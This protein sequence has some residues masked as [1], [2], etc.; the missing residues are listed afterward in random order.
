MYLKRLES[1]LV[2]ITILGTGRGQT[3]RQ[4]PKPAAT[5]E[6]KTLEITKGTVASSIPLID[7]MIAPVHCSSDGTLYF[8]GLHNPATEPISQLYS[9]SSQGEG[10]HIARILPTDY[11]RTLV[12]DLFAG[13]HSLATLIEASQPLSNV[14]GDLPMIAYYLSTSDRDGDRRNLTQLKLTFQPKKIAVLESGRFLVLGLD[15]VN[16][17][18]V[19]AMLETDGTFLR[20][21]DINSLD[22]EH[23]SDLATAYAKP[24]DKNDPGTRLLSTQLSAAAFVPWGSKILLLQAGSRLPLHVFG[25]GGEEK[26]IPLALPPGFLLQYILASEEGPVLFVRTQSADE[27]KKFTEAGM[28]VNPTQQVLE[29]AVDTGKP[30]RSFQIKGAQPADIACASNGKFTALYYKIGE[31]SPNTVPQPDDDKLFV[32]SIPR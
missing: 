14:N 23:S 19:L 25:N 22:Y 13:Q 21:L 3:P 26:T 24:A 11:K 17:I 2:I 32:A 27:F 30:I 29:F 9:V 1:F 20:R 7:A 28:I 31:P 4:D 6:L 12:L 16:R 18:P 15:S 5:T 10:T 8:D